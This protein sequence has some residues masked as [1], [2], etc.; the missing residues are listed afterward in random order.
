MLTAKSA[1]ELH[2]QAVGYP[3]KTP[4]DCLQNFLLIPQGNCKLAC[5]EMS[6]LGVVTFAISRASILSDKILEATIGTGTTD[7]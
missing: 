6:R 3:Q 4:K 5:P 1:L 7:L 2:L